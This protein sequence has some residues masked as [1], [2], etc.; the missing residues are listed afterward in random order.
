MK[1]QYNWRTNEEP[2][3]L[4]FYKFFNNYKNTIVLTTNPIPIAF[5]DI[6]MIHFYNNVDDAVEIYNQEKDKVGIIIYTP[7]FYPCFNQ[8]CLDK[9]DW[10]FTTINSTNTLL[11]HEKYDQDYYIYLNKDLK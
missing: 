8:E 10:L 2:P 5:S 6:K 3:I 7:E 11:F 4:E 1:E 9:K